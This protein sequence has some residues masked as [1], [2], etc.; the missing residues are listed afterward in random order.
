MA[1]CEVWENGVGGD[2]HKALTINEKAD[3]DG[4]LTGWQ[5]LAESNIESVAGKSQPASSQSA[6]SQSAF[7][8]GA[9]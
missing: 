3:F 7:P 6:A 5:M 2:R 1:E 4:D 9:N 8:C